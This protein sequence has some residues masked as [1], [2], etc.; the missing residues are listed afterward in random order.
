MSAEGAVSTAKTKE[1]NMIVVEV[2]RTPGVYRQNLFS[3][4]GLKRW[5]DEHD[6]L[7]DCRIREAE[8]R[9]YCRLCKHHREY[10][11]K[12]AAKERKAKYNPK[13][14]RKSAK[15]GVK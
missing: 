10:L 12:K 6:A 3:S 2:R 11:A 13:S 4:P 15:K 7:I 8:Q 14:D 1:T 9:E 5:F